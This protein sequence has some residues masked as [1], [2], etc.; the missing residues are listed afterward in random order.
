M[1]LKAEELK[2]IACSGCIQPRRA[3]ELKQLSVIDDSE[4]SLSAIAHHVLQQRYLLKDEFGRVKETPARMF[5]RV[6]KAVA[7]AD[8]IY[9]SR[10][11]IPKVQEEFY[12]IMS[13]LDFLPNSPT[14]MNAGTRLG[15]LS[16]CFV[17]PV[18][19]TLEGI[20]ET[21]K[22]MALVQRSGAGVG[23]SFSSLRPR[24]DL[25]KSTM[26]QTSGPVSFIRVFDYA[27]ETI[28]NG[29]KR[30]GA[31]MA[32]LRVDHPDIAEFVAAKS[33]DCLSNFNLSVA[34]TDDFMRKVIRRETYDL[35][36]PRTGT[37]VGQANAADMLSL[38]SEMAWKTG[39]PG[40]I[41]IDEINRYNP[42]PKLGRIESTNPCGEQ[43]LLSYESCNIGSINLSH[44]YKDGGVDW[45]KLGETIDVA[46]HFLD[47]VID[48]TQFPLARIERMTKSNRKIGLGVM[49]FADLLAQMRIPYDSG[50]AVKLA[51]ELMRFISRNAIRRS[52]ELAEERGSFSNF[53]GSRWERKGYPGIRNATL[54]TVAPT[55]TLR[56]IAGCS[57]GVEPIFAISYIRRMMDGTIIRE[58]NPVFVK[59]AQQDGFYSEELMDRIS[60]T[61]SV[62]GLKEI[63][64]EVRKVFVTSLDI[65]PEWHVGMQAAFQRHCDNA[66]SKTVNLPEHATVEDVRSVF[67]LA[68]KL[69][70]KGITV[71]RY[72]SKKQQVLSI[73]ASVTKYDG[74]MHFTVPVDYAGNC[75]TEYCTA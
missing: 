26:G 2:T 23:F 54:T 73:G 15:Q 19:D 14:L 35:V 11:D 7:S 63:P 48:V 43:P 46:I 62:R 4:I 58:A 13:N 30:R 32:I 33:N 37:V 12:M 8:L 17:L 44:M 64:Y 61:G 36:N 60:E 21:L 3:P 20:F 27:T 45:N 18:Q 51:D 55:G 38:I 53:E 34:V 9:D 56:I 69:R 25:L 71:F 59:R 1:G 10:A 70:C 52:V 29:G 24:G 57:S 67:L 50:R 22:H 6:A 49:G 31:N 41:F 66:V 74:R 39:D 42:T 65:S 72:G 28:K 16:A 5:R 47:N 40:L 68:H 75:M